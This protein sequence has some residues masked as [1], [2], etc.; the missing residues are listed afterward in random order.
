MNGLITCEWVSK[1]DNVW[2]SQLVS[3]LVSLSVSQLVSKLVSLWK[4]W[5]LTDEYDNPTRRGAWNL[6]EESIKV[7]KI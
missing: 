4:S 3:Q 2:V 5:R 6:F 1:W 7:R